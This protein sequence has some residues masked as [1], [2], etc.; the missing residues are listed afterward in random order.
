M[1][2]IVN[3]GIKHTLSQIT[4][5]VNGKKQISNAA[6]RGYC[7]F[8]TE[9]KDCVNVYLRFMD[10]LNIQLSSFSVLEDNDVVYIQPSMIYTLWT[11]LNFMILPFLCILLLVLKPTIKFV[12]YEWVCAGI[13]VLTAISLI[14]MQVMELIPSICKR[15]FKTTRIR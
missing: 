12:G 5:L 10:G 14:T 15:L 9:G 3:K 6:I 8:H 7:E 2:L 11:S 13:V 4:I 1:K